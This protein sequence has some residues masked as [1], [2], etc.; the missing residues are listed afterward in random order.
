[1]ILIAFVSLVYTVIM[2]RWPSLTFDFMVRYLR[3]KANISA[4]V[5]GLIDTYPSF[6]FE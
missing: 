5:F 4:Y 2:G 1:M 6:R 3:Y